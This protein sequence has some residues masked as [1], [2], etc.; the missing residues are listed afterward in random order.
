MARDGKA[1]ILTGVD[2]HRVNDQAVAALAN[3]AEM[4]SR[5]GFLVRVVDDPAE[6]LGH[7]QIP[8][9]PRIA[10]TTRPTLRERLTLVADWFKRVGGGKDGE[11][12]WAPI[13]PPDACV[14][15]VIDRGRWEGV[16]KLVAV[17]DYPIL[18]RSGEIVTTPGYHAGSGLHYSPL[19]P[20][21]LT[22]PDWPTTAAVRQAVAAL[23]EVVADF[24]FA[25][26]HHRAAWVA[27]LFT[28]LAR[29]TYR[30][31]AP[32]F[33][34]EAN[35]PAAGKGLL[36]D[37][38]GIT[39]RGDGFAVATYPRDDE[40][41]R[42]RVTTMLVRGATLALFDN[43]SGEFGG[44]SL[45]ALL[46]ASTW[47]DRILGESRDVSVPQ[48]CS[49]FATAN[50][51]SLVGDTARRVCPIRLDSPHERPEERTDV[52][53]KDLRAWVR[54]ERPR[55]LSAALTIL[56]AYL[57]AGMPDQKV[58][59]WGS[60]E[61]WSQVVRGAVV[62]AGWPDPAGGRVEMRE[63]ADTETVA[64]GVLL[65][66]WEKVA[67]GGGERTAAQIV[68]VIIKLAEPQATFGE[69]ERDADPAVGALLF[70][71]L[72]NLIGPGRPEARPHKLGCRFRKYQKRI[73][74]GRYI[75]QAGKSAGNLR[76]V[77]CDAGASPPSP[78]PDLLAGGDVGV[79][80]D[81][82]THAG[83]GFGGD[84]EEDHYPQEV[85]EPPPFAP[86]PP[87][88]DLRDSDWGRDDPRR[89]LL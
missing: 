42:K 34:C 26:E 68:D 52:R 8:A 71:A 86:S 2:E 14:S 24:P 87:R 80:G 51:P 49:W 64:M 89:N 85:P 53:H 65:S 84:S 73:I 66:R 6:D 77:V 28:V 60:Y 20:V 19:V 50:N 23:D 10:T 88:C 18:L 63:R 4:F 61:A 40:E 13:A 3:D 47:T 67:P 21:A 17:V 59:T 76:W 75:V 48:L 35:V 5:G 69:S 29:Y 33:M 25:A 56:R 41:L 31:C 82:G 12:K 38:I 58:P 27:G 15:A 9:G 43:V 55:L 16:R 37:T 70:E 30:G 81:S 62:W 11:D 1:L 45:D 54:A 78:P 44:S 57:K 46:T 83:Q 79:G 74:G 72:N 36:I 7:V 39:A 32:L 22:V